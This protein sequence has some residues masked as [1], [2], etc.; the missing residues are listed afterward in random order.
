L[1]IIG[2]IA[3]TTAVIT[4]GDE[5][6]AGVSVNGNEKRHQYPGVEWKEESRRY[7]LVERIRCEY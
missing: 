4:E 2:F 3:A 5:S 1:I 6:P 7:A